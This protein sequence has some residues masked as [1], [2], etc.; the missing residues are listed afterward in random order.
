M[1]VKAATASY[2]CDSMEFIEP[3]KISKYVPDLG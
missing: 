1:L 2:E 3:S